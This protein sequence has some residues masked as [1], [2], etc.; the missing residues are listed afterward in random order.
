MRG[1]SSRHNK[2]P[3]RGSSSKAVRDA[4]KQELQVAIDAHKKLTADLAAAKA[5]AARTDPDAEAV[6]LVSK[7]RLQ[8]A[9]RHSTQSTAQHNT[10]HIRC[11]FLQLLPCRLA[12]HAVMEHVRFGSVQLRRSLPFHLAAQEQ[13]LTKSMLHA[14]VSIPRPR[15]CRTT[16]RLRRRRSALPSTA[17]VH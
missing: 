17:T 2:D 8:A 10:Q 13:A 11:C 16:W 7:V 1:S 3:P 4:A 14:G 6:Q 15:S 9:H 12:M 5:A